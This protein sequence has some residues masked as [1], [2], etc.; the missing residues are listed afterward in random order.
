MGQARPISQDEEV[1]AHALNYSQAA[2]IALRNE[3][4]LTQ[5]ATNRVIAMVSDPQFDA[6]E[7]GTDRVQQLE[8]KL[9]REFGGDVWVF[10]GFHKPMDGN[11]DTKMISSES[12]LVIPGSQAL[13]HF[14][15]SL[16]SV[17][18]MDNGHLVLLWVACGRKSLRDRLGRKTFC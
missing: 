16:L 17:R 12:F 2:V 18:M 3:Q 11:Q 5:E 7:I 10:D 15:L 9:L 6:R 13:S 1:L 8:K 14:H 4:R